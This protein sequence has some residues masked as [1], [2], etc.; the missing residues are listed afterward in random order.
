MKTEQFSIAG[1]GSVWIRE[2]LVSVLRYDSGDAGGPTPTIRVTSL[3]GSDIDLEMVPG[4]IVKLPRPMGG[5]VIRSLAGAGITGKFT[6]G[7]GS[8]EDNTFSGSFDLTMA[9][10]NALINAKYN[11]RPEAYTP[12]M[13]PVALAAGAVQILAP[14]ANTNGFLVQELQVVGYATSGGLGFLLAKNGAPTAAN[15]GDGLGGCYYTAMPSSNCLFG[16]VQN[17][18]VPPGKG[19]YFWGVPGSVYTAGWSYATLVGKAL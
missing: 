7:D 14:G 11:T 10:I 15:D 9:T 12:G 5:I 19:I 4:R 6:W 16:R 1:A 17:V 13:V 2:G 18:V 3:S 8:V